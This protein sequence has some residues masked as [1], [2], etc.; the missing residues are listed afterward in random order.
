MKI[1]HPVLLMPYGLEKIVI[2]AYFHTEV[3]HMSC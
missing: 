3:F 2:T 1:D